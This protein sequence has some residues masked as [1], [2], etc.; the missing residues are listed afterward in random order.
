MLI[1]IVR[2]RLSR[3]KR[4]RVLGSRNTARL[5]KRRGDQSPALV[6]WSRR[7]CGWRRQRTVRLG[8]SAH[9]AAERPLQTLLCLFCWADRSLTA[10]RSLSTLWPVRSRP[11]WTTAGPRSA[12]PWQH[13]GWSAGSKVVPLRNTCRQRAEISS[14]SFP[15]DL[16]RE[17]FEKENW[18]GGCEFWQNV[19]V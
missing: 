10:R 13:V 18:G 7:G 8:A 15:L 6:V 19:D 1:V 3:G 4:G 12:A 2:I 11:R 17:L 16:M 14:P 9:C 5:E